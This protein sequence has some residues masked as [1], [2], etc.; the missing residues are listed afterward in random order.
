MEPSPLS[1]LLFIGIMNDL[2][3]L[4]KSAEVNS[5]GCQ[6]DLDVYQQ[7]TILR[8]GIITISKRM[9]KVIDLLESDN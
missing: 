7:R 2:N 6:T 8:D 1:P 5:D 4:L 9:E 3:E